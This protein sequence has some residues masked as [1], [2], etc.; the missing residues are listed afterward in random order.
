M[1]MFTLAVSCLITSKLP[2]FMGLTVQVPMQ[3]CSLQHQSLSPTPVTSTTGCCFC[4]D[5]VSSFF[6]E[7]DLHWPPVAYWAPTNMG[8]SSFSVLSF[9]PYKKWSS[10]HSQQSLNSSTRMQSQKWQNS[11]C[12]F[13]RQT[14]QYHSNPNLCSDQ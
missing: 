1:S 13:P 11:L 8:S 3:F 6:I 5:T 12:S 7:L 10:R 4:F 9:L 14:I 2:W